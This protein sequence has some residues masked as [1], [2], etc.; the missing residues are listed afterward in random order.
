MRK[1]ATIKL[2]RGR[3]GWFDELTNIHLT[4]AQPIADVYDVM[5]T[6]GILSGIKHGTITLLAGDL[7]SPAAMY[8][9]AQLIQEVKAINHVPEV[10]KV[11]ETKKPI[12]EVECAGCAFPAEEKEEVKPVE[13]APKKKATTSKKKKKATE[14]KKNIEE[15]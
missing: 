11:K 12:E 13:E 14:T 1:V 15:K 7:I 6:D 4:I 5:N 10:A 2:A 3:A 9:D 8:D